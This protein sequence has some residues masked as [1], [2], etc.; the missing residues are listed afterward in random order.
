MEELENDVEDLKGIIAEVQANQGVLD[1]KVRAILAKLSIGEG[2]VNG[3]DSGGEN[4]RPPQLFTKVDLPTFDRF[5]KIYFDPFYPEAW[6]IRAEQFFL[7]H[8]IPVTN[9][10]K[11]ALG[12]MPESA[13]AWVLLLLRLNP[14]L[15]W[16]QFSQELLVRFGNVSNFNEYE[17]L[18]NTTQTGS[19]EHYIFKFESKMARLKVFSE[20][21]CVGYF[22]AGLKKSLRAQMY[23]MI[24]TYSM[25]IKEARKLDH[26]TQSNVYASYQM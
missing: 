24:D 13:V 20:A 15:T 22:L 10:V 17:A 14:E 19:L 6:L 2:S 4:S 16:Q 21:K 9:R 12:A 23:P 18:K 25:A 5:K 3:N 1:A 11:Y 8:D 26:A 7:V